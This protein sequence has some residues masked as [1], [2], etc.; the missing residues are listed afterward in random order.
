MPFRRLTRNESAHL[1]RDYAA[2]WPARE[3]TGSMIPR[4]FSWFLVLI[5]LRTCYLYVIGRPLPRS[6]GH[7]H[8]CFLVH[9]A[10]PWS[11]AF[12]PRLVPPGLIDIV[13][14]CNPWGCGC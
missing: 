9:N 3:R 5:I 12:T 8:L 2:E 4:P 6:A 13:M 11:L 10:A 14:C 7:W 1:R